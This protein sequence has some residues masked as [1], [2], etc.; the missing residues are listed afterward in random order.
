G[1]A[2]CG[3]SYGTFQSLPSGW[4][5]ACLVTHSGFWIVELS[6]KI[7]GELIRVSFMLALA[8]LWLA[9]CSSQGPR[10]T[11]GGDHHAVRFALYDQFGEWRGVPYRMGGLSKSGVDC[12]GLVYLTFR[13]RFGIQLP[14]NTA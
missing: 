14:R 12:S 11:Q 3:S 8:C 10:T 9:A 13:D 1:T 4:V 7:T 6:Q 5:V 2:P